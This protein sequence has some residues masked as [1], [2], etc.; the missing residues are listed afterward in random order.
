MSGE[1]GEGYG[2][3]EG[4]KELQEVTRRDCMKHE[5]FKGSVFQGVCTIIAALIT[6]LACAGGVYWIWN[7]VTVTN[8]GNITVNG[9]NVNYVEGDVNV[10]NS[11][12]NTY[13]M[14]ISAMSEE[15]KLD[16][17]RE[18]C[19]EGDFDKAYDIYSESSEQVALLNLGYIYANG[20][21]YVG[22]DLE[23]AEEC[24]S[25]ADCTEGKR[26]LFILYLEN[27]MME[28][29][30]AVCSDLLWEIDD[31]LTWD[32]IANCLYKKT[33]REYQE[34]SGATKAEFS[35]DSSLLFEWSYVDNYYSGYTPPEDTARSRW[36]FQSIGYEV[37]EQVNHPY[38]TYREQRIAYDRMVEVM[39]GLY[40]ED[41]GKMY[42]ITN[43]K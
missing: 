6:L 3:Y 9:E 13:T 38:V 23:K 43:K 19:T 28:K 1:V 21:A 4:V 41:E 2:G 39:E 10:N 31:N 34:E 29:A 8:S 32:Y 26:G 11:V 35:F 5:S 20:H 18:A 37:D 15:N 22:K 16:I 17:A 33:W 40:Y 24:Y 36:V 7:R 30:Q 25:K 42:P 14:D 27:G 12:R